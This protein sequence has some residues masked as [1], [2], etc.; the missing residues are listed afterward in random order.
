[1]S[2]ERNHSKILMT[3]LV[4]V[5]CAGVI[6]VTVSVVLSMMDKGTSRS[7]SYYN[8]SDTSSYAGYDSYN[9]AAEPFD[10]LSFSGFLY[11]KSKHFPT[12]ASISGSVYNGNNFSVYGYFYIIFA[13]GGRT[14]HRELVSIG[15][16][17]P[18]KTGTWSDLIYSLDYDTISYEDSTIIRK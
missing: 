7:E 12:N 13:K 18:N 10:Q 9:N 2:Q 17:S 15:T 6:T 16:V 3:L 1:M 14:V 4:V 8:R 5:L 11:E